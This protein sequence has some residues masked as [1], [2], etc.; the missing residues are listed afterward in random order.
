MLS[1]HLNVLF[2]LIDN[3][4]GLH[5]PLERL[6]IIRMENVCHVI[7]FGLITITV[8]GVSVFHLWM[9]RRCFIRLCSQ[10]KP[11][12]APILG[13]FPEKIWSEVFDKRGSTTTINQLFYEST[14]KVHY[15]RR[16]NF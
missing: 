12:M 5:V 3:S 2:V 15:L 13:T 1:I 6:H 8:R 4:L 14:Q 10:K 9:R 11:G 7:R 16:K